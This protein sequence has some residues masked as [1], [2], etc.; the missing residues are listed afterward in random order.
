MKISRVLSLLLLLFL[1]FACKD[2]TSA[3]TN[4]LSLVRIEKALD[5]VFYESIDFNYDNNRNLKRIDI[6]FEDFL[7]ESYEINYDG[8]EFSS[9]IH[10]I[11]NSNNG[12]L[13]VTEYEIIQADN[14]FTL[15]NTE[16]DIKYTLR[17]T[18]G[19]VD[20]YKTFH[21]P[22]NQHYDEVIFQRHADNNIKNIAI[23]GSSSDSKIYNYYFSDYDSTF[24]LPNAY[25]PVMH[26]HYSDYNP[27]I[28]AVMGFKISDHPPLVSSYW[29]AGGILLQP[30]IVA[31]P[32]VED[33]VLQEFLHE[34]EFLGRENNLLKVY[35]Q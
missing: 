31:T 25:N 8:T 4:D 20:Y 19:Y 30:N 24:S 16:G 27:Y 32:I 29:D 13:T 2:N 7:E 33:G 23:Y 1:F 34:E 6:Q 9:L 35:Y 21:G 14:E 17:V 18:N 15:K 26:F 5:G 12:E 3:P 11:N 10:T 28:A 22:N